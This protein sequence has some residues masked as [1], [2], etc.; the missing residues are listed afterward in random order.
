MGE[1]DGAELESWEELEAELGGSWRA[2][3]SW[4]RS[5]EELEAELGGSWDGAL[6]GG[7]EAEQARKKYL[8]IYFFDLMKKCLSEPKNV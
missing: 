1:L 5:W 3:R 4:R 8:H 2:G 7:W 6:D